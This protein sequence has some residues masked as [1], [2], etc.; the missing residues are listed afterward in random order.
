MDTIDYAKSQTSKSIALGFIDIIE[1]TIQINEL[2]NDTANDIS[3]GTYSVAELIELSEFG[4]AT[5]PSKG[6]LTISDKKVVDSS[7]LANGYVVDCEGSDCT[8][9][10][11]DIREQP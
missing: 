2:D 9:S 10:N 11:G 6:W 4:S 3:D 8:V 7:F 5:L 1:N